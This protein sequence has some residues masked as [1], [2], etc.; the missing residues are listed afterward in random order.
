MSFLARNPEVKR[1]FVGL[2]GAKHVPNPIRSFQSTKP[3]PASRV[4]DIFPTRPYY[5]T[6]FDLTCR[7]RHSCKQMMTPHASLLRV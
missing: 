2:L 7:F 4:S 6:L 1:P 3:N 5:F